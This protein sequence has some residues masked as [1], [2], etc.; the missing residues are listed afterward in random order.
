MFLDVTNLIVIM[1]D[2]DVYDIISRDDKTILFL[3]NTGLIDT[4]SYALLQK[5]KLNMLSE[6]VSYYKRHKSFLQ[7]N[8]CGQKTNIT[9]INLAKSNEHL[10]QRKNGT[11]LIKSGLLDK[12]HKGEKDLSISISSVSHYYNL[13][14]RTTGVLQDNNL[15]TVEAFLKFFF[16]QGC[17]LS[18]KKCGYKSNSELV[19]FANTLIKDC[20]RNGIIW[21]S[22]K[23]IEPSESE[24][25]VSEFGT[26][27]LIENEELSFLKDQ[28]KEC[29]VKT[30]QLLSFCAQKYL[31]S[32][33]Y[34][35]FK[36]RYSYF[37]CRKDRTYQCIG[38]ELSM[39]GYR[40]RQILQ[41][42]IRKFL[43][44]YT[45]LVKKIFDST[46]T[47]KYLAFDNDLLFIDNRFVEGVNRN[48]K[49][50]F[51]Y[52][53]VALLFASVCET[54]SLFTLKYSKRSYYYLIHKDLSDVFSFEN[55][56]RRVVKELDI[57]SKKKMNLNTY[58]LIRKRLSQ[59]DS[60]VSPRVVTVCRMIIADALNLPVDEN[61][62]IML[63]LKKKKSISKEIIDVL[64]KHPNV[65]LDIEKLLKLVKDEKPHLTLNT[66]KIRHHLFQIE[67]LYYIGRK[68]TYI[69]SE[70]CSDE[71]RMLNG[72]LGDISV[73]Y[74]KN[75]NYPVH[76]YEIVRYINKYLPISQ[77]SL[78]TNL[79][80]TKKNE[81]EFYMNSFIGY[82]YSAKVVDHKS[83]PIPEN[84]YEKILPEIGLINYNNLLTIK[85]R[86][87]DRF[88]HL[89][90]LFINV[91]GGISRNLSFED[92]VSELAGEF[93]LSHMQVL[94]VLEPKINNGELYLDEKGRLN[95]T[96]CV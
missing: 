67:N 68:S 53:I 74:L 1:E 38:K 17:F 14:K 4:R 28:I 52:Y 30:F 20:E 2:S 49:T 60:D 11:L 29:N 73:K 84:L 77:R 83:R 15:T 34:Y 51:N 50:D 70:T 37:T 91:K 8:S 62:Q 21:F 59:Q 12:K 54:H 6:I 61:L 40:V 66:Q 39:T 69:Y 32:S 35:I 36:T 78:M 45:L 18:L 41:N 3:K 55:Y 65:P 25:I 71:L 85:K 96:K 76:I 23:A 89:E 80:K 48:E 86:N 56:F 33:T 19:E 57:C 94:S 88:L 64:R 93:K 5:G 10:F 75:T 81:I 90:K 63:A 26:K 43:C 46:K 13:E 95:S 92:L 22:K 47:T 82:K 27:F 79:Q 44:Q 87:Y 7:I 9:L 16:K 42:S 31:D 58:S 72:T 24:R